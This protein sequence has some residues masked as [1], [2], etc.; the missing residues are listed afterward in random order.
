M[1][2]QTIGPWGNPGWILRSASYV[3]AV[4]LATA[5]SLLRQSGTPAYDSIWAED[6]LVF[7][8][9]AIERPFGDTF[10]EPYRGY[11]LL[12]PRALA[13][14]AS[15]LPLEYAAVVMSGGAAFLVGLLA[16]F[17]YRASE[18]ISHIGLRL[19]L[20]VAVILLPVAGVEALNSAANVHWYLIFAAFWA[21]AWYPR[22]AA[23]R[24]VA[25]LVAALA[26]LNDPLA[27]LLAPVV[28]LRAA[29][30]RRW[31]DHWP[32]AAWCVGLAVQGIAVASAERE[33]LVGAALPELAAGYGALVVALTVLGAELAGRIWSSASVLLAWFGLM[34]A[35]GLTAY[36]AARLERPASRLAIAAVACSVLLFAVP[37]WLR[38]VEYSIGSEAL[39]LP[40]SRYLV[41]PSLL[42]LSAA[43]LI[44]DSVRTPRAA[45]II[46][47][48]WFALVAMTNFTMSN[49]RDAGPSWQEAVRGAR[50]ACREGAVVTQVPI[51][52]YGWQMDV[53]CSSIDTS[54][55][56]PWE[57]FPARS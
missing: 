32:T 15:V 24:L 17:V 56:V 4:A 20:G 52:P 53:Q 31:H 5:A 35:A 44:L 26:A 36:C 27:L 13:W 42:V 48:A 9:D 14:I 16:A 43:A 33:P 12:L 51:A 49:G 7:L 19:A 57:P 46:V 34:V 6:A 21:F 45:L 28:A 1:A 40:G 3:V 50:Q 22:S 54:W 11:V 55:S 37:F 41:A 18:S 23:L 39:T 38:G 30:S 8:S 2:Q 10:F 47:G 29:T 25:A